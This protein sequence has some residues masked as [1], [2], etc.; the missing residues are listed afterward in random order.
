MKRSGGEVVKSARRALPPPVLTGGIPCKKKMTAQ[1]VDDPLSDDPNLDYFRERGIR[2]LL[3]AMLKQSIQDLVVVRERPMSADP[4]QHIS[5]RWLST[6]DAIGCI[7][8]LMPDVCPEVAVARI[9]DDPR[10]VLAALER[11]VPDD[12]NESDGAFS[13]G[14]SSEILSGIESESDLYVPSCAP[15]FD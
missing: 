14:L 12:A 13:Y 5:A 11:K 2:D 1:T 9:Q 8:F 10:A 6:P 15:G 3:A 4:D 7:S